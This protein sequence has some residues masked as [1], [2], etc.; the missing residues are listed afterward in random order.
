MLEEKS[1]VLPKSRDWS[2]FIIQKT[3]AG[4]IILD[5]QGHVTDCNPAAEEIT[6]YSRDQILSRLATEVLPCKRGELEDCPIRLVMRGQNVEN[7]ELTL[8]SSSGQEVPV[9]LRAFALEDDLGV[10]LGGVI[11]FQDLTSVKHLEKERRHLVN[12]FAHDLKTPIVGMAGL[13]R[14]LSQGKLGPLSEAQMAY[15]ETIDTGMRTLEDLINKFLEFARLDLGFLTPL[16]SA[17]QVEQEC[18][19]IIVS[20]LP[21]AEAKNIEL[22]TEFPQE[23]L[24][25]Q[26]DPLLFRRVLENLLENAIKYSPRQTSVLLQV[27]KIDGEVQFAVRDQG[28]GILPQNVPHIFE[29]F[30]RGKGA[31]KNQGF[32]LGLAT[33]KRIIDAHGGR[34]WVDTTPEGTKFIFTLPLE[35]VGQI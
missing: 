5:G 7:Q 10:K 28:P 33:V 4:I 11:I 24:V 15:L 8:L 27:Q 25:L 14:R 2:N 6:G 1:A 12:I 20:L 29:I 3:P 16:P 13:I 18:Q 34:I 22:A 35:S 30:Y 23:I 9:M 26:A 31:G 19:E 17:I 21:L 32:G